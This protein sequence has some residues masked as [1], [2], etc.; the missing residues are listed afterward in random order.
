MVTTSEVRRLWPPAL[1]SAGNHTLPALNV[2]AVDFLYANRTV[3]YVHHNMSRSGIVCADADDF[4]RRTQLPL[5]ALFP[6][7]TSE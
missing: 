2:R 7:V 4:S 1:P 6:D 3:C 5:P